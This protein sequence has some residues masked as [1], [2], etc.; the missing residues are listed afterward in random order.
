MSRRSTPIALAAMAL[1]ACSAAQAEGIAYESPNFDVRLYGLIDA[2]LGMVDHATAGGGHKVGFGGSA[3]GA[4]WFSGARWGIAGK[5]KFSDEGLSV[6]FKLENEYLIKD[7][8]ADDS[9]AAFGRDAWIGVENGTI[10][11]LTFGR[12]NTVARDFAQIY[13]DAYGSAKVGLD[14]GGWTNGNNFKQLLFYAGSASGTRYKSG[15]VWKKDFGMGLVAGAGFQFGETAGDIKAGSTQ[16]LA[17]GYNGGAFN[18]AGFATH[19][20][21]NTHNH[22]AYSI[23][24]NMQF[25]IVRVNTGYF[26]YRADQAAL[27]TRT[28][29]AWTLSAKITPPGKLDYELGYQVMKAE[30]A[31]VNKGSVINAFADGSALTAAATGKR[32]TLYTSVFYHFDKSTEVYVAADYL[33]LDGGYKQA[34]TNGYSTQTELGVGLRFRF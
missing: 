18:V 33:K 13:G 21:V 4:P 30:N 7:G 16:S 29:N 9:T 23:G 28:D 14:E 3:S 22:D 6:I 19:A 31:G 10:G 15:V 17:L 5:R 25:G 20:N 8:S 2:T 12:Q 32:S 34:S 27:G 24:G 1:L 11:K 26:H